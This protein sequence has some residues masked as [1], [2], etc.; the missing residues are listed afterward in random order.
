MQVWVALWRSINVGGYNRIRMEVLRS[1]FDGLGYTQV[2]TYLQSGNV[3]FSAKGRPEPDRL[4]AE[5]AARSG[6]KARV[7]LRD[8]A[9]LDAALESAPFLDQGWDPGHLYVTFL[10]SAPDPGRASALVSQPEVAGRLWLVGQ[11]VFLHL[12]EG[13]GRSRFNQGFVERHLGVN[14]TVRNWKVASALLDIM[15]AHGEG[16]RRPLV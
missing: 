6:V 10:G 11:E 7:I 13:Y 16:G 12:P 15:H 4:E 2:A 8:A 5:L 14:A 3:V 9:S 1:V